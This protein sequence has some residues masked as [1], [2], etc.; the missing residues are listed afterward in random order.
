MTNRKIEEIKQIVLNIY[1]ALEIK[2][3]PVDLHYLLESYGI[4]VYTYSECGR[5][6]CLKYS[7]DSFSFGSKIFYDETLYS[8]RIRFSIAHELGHIMLNHTRLAENKRIE[9]KEADRFAAS[10]L[11][12]LVAVSR[13]DYK[14]LELLI[15][16]FD[17][18]KKA[19]N[20]AFAEY[21]HT[22]K[23]YRFM[24]YCDKKLFD[25]LYN[26]TYNLSENSSCVYSDHMMEVAF[27][28]AE[29]NWLYGD[30]Y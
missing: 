22:Y 19:A 28:S 7:K 26:D 17:I 10:L 14:T 27:Q 2:D 12:P 3:F 5:D 11:V 1:M 13:L 20:I 6:I 9:E 29:N 30:D 23:G 18:S 25:Y 24:S 15:D 21:K 16:Y 8:K 4:Q